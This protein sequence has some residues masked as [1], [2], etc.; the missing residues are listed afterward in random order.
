MNFSNVCREQVSIGFSK[1]LHNCSGVYP[2]FIFQLD[3]M[4]VYCWYLGDVTNF[5]IFT[6][7]VLFFQHNF[8]QEVLVHKFYDPYKSISGMF[9]FIKF[10][11]S[12]MI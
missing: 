1:M 2:G 11:D 8:T 4:S 10:L 5:Y 6:Y 3:C 9:S 12:V 7:Q